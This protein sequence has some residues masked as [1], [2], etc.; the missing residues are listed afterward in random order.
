MWST[1]DPS[2]R[3]WRRLPL[4][5]LSSGLWFPLCL[6]PFRG[7]RQATRDGRPRTDAAERRDLVAPSE[8]GDG[9]KRVR[10]LPGARGLPL[11]KGP[12]GPNFDFL[13]LANGEH[14]WTVENCA[15]TRA[16]SSQSSASFKMLC[17]ERSRHCPRTRRRVVVRCALR[18]SVKRGRRSVELVNSI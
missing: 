16:P 10:V 5:R 11:E 17:G 15:S 9:R 8:G 12:A 13:S 7:A 1:R 4:G 14:S 2:A 6:P 3:T 18:G